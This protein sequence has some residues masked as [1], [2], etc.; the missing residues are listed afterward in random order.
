M[1]VVRAA[2]FYWYLS[3]RYGIKLNFMLYWVMYVRISTILEVFTYV[4]GWVFEPGADQKLRGFSDKPIGKIFSTLR[5][6]YDV[7]R[8]KQNPGFELYLLISRP[9]KELF[10]RFY[11]ASKTFIINTTWNPWQQLPDYK[12]N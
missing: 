1:R 11:H 2:D 9:K 4:N 7:V 6:F 3:K 12:N 8:F 10:N 5:K